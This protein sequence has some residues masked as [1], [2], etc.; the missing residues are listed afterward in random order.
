[1][2][3]WED[4]PAITTEVKGKGSEKTVKQVPSVDRQ[5]EESASWNQRMTLLVRRTNTAEFQVLTVV[6]ARIAFWVVTPCS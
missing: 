3:R 4:N 1:V 5:L 6:T 2:K